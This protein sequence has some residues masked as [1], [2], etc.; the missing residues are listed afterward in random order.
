VDRAAQGS[1]SDCFRGAYPSGWGAS[2]SLGND[3]SWPRRP[4]TYQHRR[5]FGNADAMVQDF[6]RVR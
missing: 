4:K 2:V 5:P 6:Q 3:Y 1:M